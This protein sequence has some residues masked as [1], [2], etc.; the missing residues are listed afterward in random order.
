[1]VSTTHT[2][3]VSY[4]DNRF[5]TYECSFTGIECFSKVMSYLSDTSLFSLHL[6]NGDDVELICLTLS[7]NYSAHTCSIVAKIFENDLFSFSLRHPINT[8]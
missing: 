8:W 1:M 3:P 4:T 5:E 2:I 7:A 6:N